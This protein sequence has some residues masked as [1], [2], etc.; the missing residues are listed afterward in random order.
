MRARVECSGTVGTTLAAEEAFRLF[1]PEG[2]RDWAEGWAPAYPAGDLPSPAPGLVFTVEREEGTSTWVVTRFEPDER[3][4]S[5]AYVL[6]GRRAAQVE[7]EVEAREDGG[8]VARVTYRITSLR[9]EEDPAVRAFAAAF[10]D[11][12]AGWEEAIRSSLES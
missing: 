5:Y 11:F 6:P 4:A 9:P 8:S 7:V 10:D 1:T 2:E 12:L 3:R